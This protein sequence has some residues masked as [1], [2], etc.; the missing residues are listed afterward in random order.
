MFFHQR[1]TGVET[2]NTD[3]DVV[4]EEGYQGPV[5]EDISA[6]PSKRP[7]VSFT[8]ADLLGQTYGSVRPSHKKTAHDK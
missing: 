8:L 7:R 4:P 6:G 1:E 5:Q 2:G 3:A